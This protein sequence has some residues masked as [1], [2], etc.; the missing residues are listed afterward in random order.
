MSRLKYMIFDHRIMYENLWANSFDE[1]LT[2]DQRL[3]YII[4]Q[5]PTHLE[6][7]HLKIHLLAWAWFVTTMEVWENLEEK[8]VLGILISN[9]VLGFWLGKVFKYD[10]TTVYYGLQKL[11]KHPILIGPFTKF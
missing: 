10:L 5:N 9:W 4:E 3:S 11:T 8:R 1:T 6:K 2:K 7:K